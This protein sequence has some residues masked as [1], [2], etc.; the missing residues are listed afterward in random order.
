M[1]LVALI[2]TIKRLQEKKTTTGETINISIKLRNIM[3]ELG[4][5]S[6]EQ[7]FIQNND[8]QLPPNESLIN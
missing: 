3:V 1:Q 2:K 4:I 7:L 8:I 6:I 5:Q